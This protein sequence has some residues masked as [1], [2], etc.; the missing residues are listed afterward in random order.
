MVREAVPDEVKESCISILLIEYIQHFC[1]DI[2]TFNVFHTLHICIDNALYV[3]HMLFLL[4]NKAYTS[5]T[6][7]ASVIV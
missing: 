6:I 3:F 5:S 4:C 1:D 2:C 7:D